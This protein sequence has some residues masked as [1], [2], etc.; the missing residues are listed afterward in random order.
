MNKLIFQ[1]IMQDFLSYKAR[2]LICTITYYS[3]LAL[4]P[5]AVLVSKTFS[6]FDSTFINPV[7]IKT[8]DIYYNASIVTMCV[9]SIVF[10]SRIFRYFY[11]TDLLIKRIVKSIFLSIITALSFFI[12]VA[13]FSLK[14]PLIKLVA[15][16][17]FVIIF[18]SILDITLFK[19]MNKT[20]LIIT[21]VFSVFIVLFAYAF[22][23]ISSSIINYEDYYGFLSPIF[24]IILE[25]YF[26]INLAFLNFIFIKYFR[27]FERINFVKM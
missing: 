17:I 26:I 22:E 12:F 4:I 9:I 24:L 2:L 15:Q 3:I 25:I 27:L 20:S 1:H 14:N 8:G 19:K 7:F 13:I 21:S 5:A 18:L 10:L 16:V 11:P 23:L 6:K